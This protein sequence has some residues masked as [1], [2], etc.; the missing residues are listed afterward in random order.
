MPTRS[1]LYFIYLFICLARVIEKKL[2]NEIRKKVKI[3]LFELNE[4]E[5]K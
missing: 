3:K 2:E 1:C 5:K 4:R